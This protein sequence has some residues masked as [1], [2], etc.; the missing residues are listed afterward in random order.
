MLLDPRFKKINRLLTEY[1]LG[2]FS[3]KI[4]LSSELDEIDSFIACINML[5]EELRETTISKNYFDNIF[6]SVSDMI[7]VLDLHGKIL[8]TSESAHET[9][10][11]TAEVYEV[12][13]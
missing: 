13:L 9:L 10:H 4:V 2:N 3:K 7:F 12:N 1:A 11:K 8:I 6:S 5:G